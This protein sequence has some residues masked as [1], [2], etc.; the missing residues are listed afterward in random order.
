MKKWLA[1]LILLGLAGN[2]NATKLTYT[3]IFSECTEDMGYLECYSR[4][5]VPNLHLTAAKVL[6]WDNALS[7]FNVASEWF[8]LRYWGDI[9]R[10]VIWEIVTIELSLG[11]FFGLAGIILRP[12]WDLLN[13]LIGVISG[14][15]IFILILAFEFVKDYLL[16]STMWVCTTRALGSD[17]E[18]FSLNR[19]ILIGALMVVGSIWLLLADWGNV[20]TDVIG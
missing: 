13:Y 17:S 11:W 9:A 2:A 20:I 19:A 1:C 14:I 3:D 8:T 7:I 4:F 10:D 18:F 12:L 15:F 6:V 16:L 5:F